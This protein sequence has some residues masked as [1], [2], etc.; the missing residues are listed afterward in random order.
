MNYVFLC[1]DQF[2]AESISCYGHPLIKTPNIDRLASEG[3]MFENCFC[4]SAL[5]T[6][7]R[8]SMFTGWYPHVVGHRTLWHLLRGDEP[9]LFRY[10]KDGGYNVGVFGKNDAFSKDYVSKCIDEYNT[11]RSNIYS[12]N[13]YEYGEDGYYSFMYKPFPGGVDETSDMLQILDGIEYMKRMRDKDQPFFLFLPIIMPHPPYTCPE[14]FYSMYNPDDIPNLRPY[15]EE[16]PEFVDMMRKYRGL[17]KMPEKFFREVNAVY[18]G[19]CSY[20]DHILGRVMKAI[21]ELGFSDN[22]TLIFSSDHGDHAGDYGCVEKIHNSYYDVLSRVPLIIRSPG[23]VCGHRVKEQVELFDIM[24][25]VMEMSNIEAHHTHFAHSLCEQLKGASG[26]PD[27]AVFAECGF[28]LEEEHCFEFWDR[29][30]R[31]WK[32]GN[33]Y[34]PQTL[35]HYEHPKS[36]C[37]TVMMRTLNSKLIRRP[38]GMDELYDL[39]EDSRETNNVYDNPEYLNMR[40]ELNERLLKWYIKTSDVVPHDHDNREFE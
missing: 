26:D 38:D 19:M 18:L 29:N 39:T 30:S 9:S 34:Y 37:R 4:Q 6:P 27:R 33:I 20:V 16:M 8:I 32:E 24:S 14:P 23:G 15:K 7:S 31:T 21:D 10:L 1:A 2:R 5:C 13:K 22:T 35:Q 25:T 12:E 17:D 11:N 36:M 28:N 40:G 3:T